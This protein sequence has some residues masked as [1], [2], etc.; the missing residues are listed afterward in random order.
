M[1]INLEIKDENI[2]DINKSFVQFIKKEHIEDGICEK[3]SNKTLYK[4][5]GI[6]KFPNVLL[7]TLK[8][9]KVDVNKI[10]N[11]IITKIQTTVIPKEYICFCHENKFY[12]YKLVSC[13][14]HHGGNNP[15][16]GHYTTNILQNNIW[17]NIDDDTYSKNIP[18][19]K[20]IYI[21][22]YNLI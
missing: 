14:N 10:N 11:P 15:N 3:C 13:I 19:V 4:K 6:F 20:D 18:D 21:L 1:D 16:R 5:T 9:F 22:L 2:T 17:Y 7:I 8:R 12:E